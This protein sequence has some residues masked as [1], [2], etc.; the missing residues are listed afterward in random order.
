MERI[1]KIGNFLKRVKETIEIEDSVKYKR[2]TIRANHQGVF[3]RDTAFG[4]TIGTKNQFRVYGGDFILSKID[5]RYGAFGIIPSELDG[6][7]ITGNFW[8]YKVD[9]NLVNT[10]WFFYFTHSP[11][12]LEICKGSSK[13]TT[14]R[15]YLDEKAFLNHSIVLPEIDEQIE[16]VRKFKISSKI[17]VS[18]SKEIQTQ[19]KLL[20]QVKQSILQEAIQGKLTEEWRKQNPSFEPA[21][22]LLERIK[23]TKVQLIKDK[24]IKKEKPLPPISEEE[25]P[26]ELPK[27]W[28]WSRLGEVLLY[29]DSGKSPNCEKRPVKDGEWGVLTTTSIQKGYFIENAN[30]VLPT[31]FEINQSHKVEKEDVLI[32]RAGPLNRTGISCKVDSIQSNL[33]L[34]DKTIRLKHPPGLLSPDFLVTILNSEAIRELL[35]PNMTGMAESQVNISQ[36]NIKITPVPIAPLDEQNAIVQKVIALMEKC[37]TLETEINQSEKY[38]QMLMQAVLKEAF[39]SQK[40]LIL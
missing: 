13:G 26:F 31:K 15:K 1:F 32:T 4:S 19:K 37:N 8:T 40:E 2:V 23:A 36:G 28:V 30:K 21:C 14:H 35:I 27:G 9:I 38:A 22:K 10:E 7:I 16:M 11:N 12:F 29:S 18:C 39:E 34:S 6:A 33:I 3:L 20:I 5:A 17:I 25:I 24:K